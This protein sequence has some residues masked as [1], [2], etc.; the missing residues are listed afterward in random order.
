MKIKKRYKHLT[1]EDRVE[2][3]V[4]LNRGETFTM[5]SKKI[6]KSASTISR[7]IKNRLV[8][9]HSGAYGMCYTDYSKL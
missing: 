6:G 2:I 4:L 5:I 3:E 7:E 9:V 8:F 1:Y